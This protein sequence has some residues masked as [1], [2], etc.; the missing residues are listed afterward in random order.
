[1]TVEFQGRDTS[2]LSDAAFDAAAKTLGCDVAS[3]KA[4]AHVE[5]PRGG[6]IPDGRPELL[7]ESHTFHIMTAGK[8]D[9]S[10]P[11][12]STPSWVRNY[13]AG[14]EHQYDRLAEAISLDRA[15]ALQ[16]ASWGKFQIMGMNYD[17]AGYHDVES[18]VQD[19]CESEAYQLD[20]F[21]CF[22]QNTG[23]D[24]FLIAHDW[25]S[26]ARSYNG[27]GQVEFYAGQIAAAYGKFA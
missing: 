18:F 27:P 11:G 9:E 12:I 26:F 15:A 10:H 8:Y 17:P 21:V 14:G 5:A 16:S 1:M 2:P 24:K 23:A 25:S 22:L 7:F 3:I 20:A 13:G 6:F 4:V 19:M